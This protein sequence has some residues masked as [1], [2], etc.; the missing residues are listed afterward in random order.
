MT[1]PLRIKGRAL[2]VP[3][4][5]VDT[6]M[7][8]H[9]RHLHIVDR[10]EMAKFMFGNLPGQTDFPV[11]A[12]PGDILITGHNF[13]CGSSRQQ[14]VDGFLAL[15]VAAI[16]GESFGAIYKRNAVNA[17]W[18]L[19]ECPGILTSGMTD[20]QEIEVDLTTG[21]V[22]DAD[23]RLIA[24]GKGLGVVQKDIYFAGGLLALAGRE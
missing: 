11:K 8:F 14:A 5:D 10:A 18:P 12:R 4:R 6:D 20:G 23:G 19:V 16:V 21:K 17:G 9:N 2:I 15:G 1:K 24:Q 7:I 13:G 3:N 22:F